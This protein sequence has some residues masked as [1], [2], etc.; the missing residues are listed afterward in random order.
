MYKHILVPTDGSKLAAKGIKEGV[1][2]AKAL[3]ATLTGVYVASPYF[4]PVYSEGAA[5]PHAFTR[6]QFDALAKEAAAKALAAIERAAHEGG[7]ACRTRV[8]TDPQPWHGIL[9]AARAARCDAI[10]MSSHGRS[11]L[12]GLLLGSETSRVLAHSRLPVLVTR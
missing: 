7:V 4:P 1:K 8:V 3:G 6:K 9:Q 5:V 2:L 12:G 10:V 11:A